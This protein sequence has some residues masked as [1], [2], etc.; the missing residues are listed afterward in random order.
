MT[1]LEDVDLS[2]TT[3]NEDVVLPSCTLVNWATMLVNPVPIT[4]IV[5]YVYRSCFSRMAALA[6]MASMAKITHC[7]RSQQRAAC[8]QVEIFI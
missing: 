8:C 5:F 6:C 4:P 3:T 1:R 7:E 2:E